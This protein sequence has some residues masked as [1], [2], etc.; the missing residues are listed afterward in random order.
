MSVR[1]RQKLI[2]DY[3]RA[4]DAYR[5]AVEEGQREHAELVEAGLI[6]ADHGQSEE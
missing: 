5:R 4:R 2:K 6:E 3:V 1:E